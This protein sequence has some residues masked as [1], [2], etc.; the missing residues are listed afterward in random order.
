[1]K[2]TIKLK[3]IVRLNDELHNFVNES[4]DLDL[5]FQVNR[6]MKIVSPLADEYI[7]TVNSTIKKLGEL[8]EDGV[9][10]TIKDTIKKNG[11]DIINPAMI[12][13]GRQKKLLDETE[14]E[15][16]HFSF[17]YKHIKGLKTDKNYP[18]FEAF[19]KE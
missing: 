15:I 12:E 9:Q 1:M 19:F 10:Y 8:T 4:I 14:H 16:E 2:T 3:N 17:R 5:K 18:T 11:K 13:F 6:L 7:D